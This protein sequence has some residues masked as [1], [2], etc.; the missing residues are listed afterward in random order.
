[1]AGCL[2]GL[3]LGGRGCVGLGLQVGVRR[4][5]GRI[6]RH[7]CRCGCVGLGLQLGDIGVRRRGIECSLGSGCRLG[8]GVGIGL[9]CVGCSAGVGCGLLGCSVFTCGGLGG[10]FEVLR[11][12]LGHCSHCGSGLSLDVQCQRLRGSGSGSAN[13]SGHLG[14]IEV[15]ERILNSG[16]GIREC[17]VRCVGIDLGGGGEFGLRVGVCTSRLGCGGGVGVARDGC[18]FE[19]LRL[20]LCLGCDCCSAV[21]GG[22]G[23]VGLGL[24]FG[25]GVLRCGDRCARCCALDLGVRGGR[26]GG[27]G[28]DVCLGSSNLGLGGV[29]A[30]GG[31]GC[32]G[33]LESY[34]GGSRCGCSFLA[35]GLGV[36]D[37][38][39]LGVG[40]L[41]N[42]IEI[43][44]G[45]A[46]FVEHDAAGDLRQWTNGGGGFGCRDCGCGGRGCVLGRD[47]RDRCVDLSFGCCGARSFYCGTLFA[48]G[49]GGFDAFGFFARRCLNLGAL[50]GLLLSTGDSR[51]GDGQGQCHGGPG[52]GE[53]RLLGP[54]DRLLRH[55]DCGPSVSGSSELRAP[56]LPRGTSVVGESHEQP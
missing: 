3:G 29:G 38:L 17:L 44:C 11:V 39:L 12:L 15:L 14:E 51:C 42:D 13:C 34:L 16:N 52:C 47:G 5:D 21:G 1:M 20:R 36:G 7:Q 54:G 40:Q 2:R 18:G 35:G 31:L 53:A 8:L 43:D 32:L 9:C 10:G 22:L 49:S 26:D 6:R 27:L 46:V 50:W 41:R 33:R 28:L 48:C 56:V 19:L 4:L 45:R 25:S 37:R 23:F 24:Q 55:G 30:R